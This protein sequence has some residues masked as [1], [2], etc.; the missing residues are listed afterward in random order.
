MYF[1]RGS[2]LVIDWH[3]LGYTLLALRLSSTHPLVSFHRLYEKFFSRFAYAHFCVTETMSHHLIQN[4]GLK[5]VSVLMDRPPKRYSPLN[6]D[7]QNLFLQTLPETR[8]VDRSTTKILVTSTSYTADEPLAPL[9][10]A[11]SRYS[12]TADPALP[13]ILLLI[14]GRGPMQEGYRKM[15]D[16]SPMAEGREGRCAIR[17]LWLQPQDYPKL[18]ACADLGI[19][20]HKSSSGMDFPMKVIDLYGCGIPVCAANFDA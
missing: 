20:L 2:R 9:L 17:M 3:N 5:N 6:R 15:I 16:R 7:A 8:D 19:S 11:L 4:Y 13:N 14:T 12:D 18:L 10:D 1:L